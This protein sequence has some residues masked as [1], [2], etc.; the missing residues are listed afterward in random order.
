VAIFNGSQPACQT[1]TGITTVTPI[2][3]TTSFNAINFP[4]G[5]TITSLTVINT[6]TATMY[7]GGSAVAGATTGVTLPPGGQLTIQGLSLA[8]GGGNVLYA[9]VTTGTGSCEVA[10]TSLVS[11]A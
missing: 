5:V 8:T 10:P 1:Y 2:Y 11:V 6:S 9:V 7:V 4:T 3:N